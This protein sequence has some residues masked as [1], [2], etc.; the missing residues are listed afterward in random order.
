MTAE[1]HG[2][3]SRPLALICD[4]VQCGTDTH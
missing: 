4:G 3:G 1:G 2:H